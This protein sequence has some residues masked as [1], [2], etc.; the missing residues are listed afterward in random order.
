MDACR[1]WRRAGLAARWGAGLSDERMVVTLELQSEHG[2]PDRAHRGVQQPA[3]AAPSLGVRP[4]SCE[5]L[6]NTSMIDRDIVEASRSCTTW[7]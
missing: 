7:Q 5:E 6:L 1:S 3:S 2:D 4:S